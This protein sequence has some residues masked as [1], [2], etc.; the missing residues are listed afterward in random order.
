MAAPHTSGWPVPRA[1]SGAAEAFTVHRGGFEAADKGA[2]LGRGRGPQIR[3]IATRGEL[4][5][6]AARAIAAWVR[7]W[8][9]IVS[10]YGV[11]AMT[12]ST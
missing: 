2:F 6:D 8:K 10:V 11:V 5:A 7:T 3:G 1:G 12:R 9:Q 4:G